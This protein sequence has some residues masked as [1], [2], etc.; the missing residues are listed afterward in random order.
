[1]KRITKKI[2]K[3]IIDRVKKDQ[4]MV[5]WESRDFDRSAV[6]VILK[7]GKEGKGNE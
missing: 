1:M 4:P 2:E 6:E 7:N 3:E 5:Y